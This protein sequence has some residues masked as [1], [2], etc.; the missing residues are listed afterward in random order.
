MGTTCR[1]EDEKQISTMRSRLRGRVH[2][3][4]ARR[5]CRLE[6]GGVGDFCRRFSEGLW[7]AGRKKHLERSKHWRSWPTSRVGGW[8]VFSDVELRSK[9]FSHFA[10]I[11]QERLDGDRE[12]FSRFRSGVC[13][14][15]FPFLER[16][17]L[18]S[19]EDGGDGG[20]RVLRISGNARATKS[21]A[22]ESGREPSHVLDD[23]ADPASN[24][25]LCGQVP[26][27]VLI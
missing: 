7:S 17:L 9:D 3:V 11:L 8:G 14:F 1:R 20:Q 12:R 2:T 16:P 13:Q 5:Q 24:G 23:K 10:R 6:Y 21:V 27:I 4:V 26:N 15:T 19:D 22:R 25:L 18:Q